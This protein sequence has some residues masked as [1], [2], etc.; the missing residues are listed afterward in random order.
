MDRCFHNSSVRKEGKHAGVVTAILAIKRLNR[1]A[2][3]AFVMKGGE[4]VGVVTTVHASSCGRW[5]WRWG[6]CC[7]ISSVRKEG[8]HK[9]VVTTTFTKLFANLLPSGWGSG[10]A[11]GDITADCRCCSPGPYGCGC[12]VCDGS[13]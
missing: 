6:R 12:H 13:R 7:H 5:R 8:Q 1:C 2:H 3:S 9:G 10:A 11:V 4:H